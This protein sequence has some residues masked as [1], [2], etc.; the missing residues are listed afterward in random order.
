MVFF[1]S[2]ALIFLGGYFYFI[3]IYIQ[4]NLYNCFTVSR[5]KYSK[6]DNSLLYIYLYICYT[7]TLRRKNRKAEKAS[8][9]TNAE[10][11]CV[12]RTNVARIKLYIYTIYRC[13]LNIN[14]FFNAKY[15][16]YKDI[17]LMIH[18]LNIFMRVIC[19]IE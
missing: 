15:I 3:S 4:I 1:K 12:K 17:Y 19:S 10:F 5:R 2:Q 18:S 8:K 6:Y 14:I 7:F 9:A 11:E 13:C 16:I